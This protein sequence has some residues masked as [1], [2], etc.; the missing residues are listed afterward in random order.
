M[1][2]WHLLELNEPMMIERMLAY[3][4]HRSKHL[5]SYSNDYLSEVLV[6]LTAVE[7][8]EQ[9]AVTMADLDD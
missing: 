1:Q 3:A 7:H 2:N 9:L 4:D 8:R 5:R 6:R